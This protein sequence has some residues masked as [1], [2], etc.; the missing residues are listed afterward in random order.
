MI[1]ENDW[2]LEDNKDC[3]YGLKINPVCSEETLEHLPS[4]KKCEF[5]W[6]KVGK[7]PHEFWYIPCIC[8]ISFC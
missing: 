3:F 2:R 5:C 7:Y 4:M 8:S 6:D 1:E